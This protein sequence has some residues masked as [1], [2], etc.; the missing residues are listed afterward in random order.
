MFNLPPLHAFLK[1]R[2]PLSRLRFPENIQ[3]LMTNQEK[4]IFLPEPLLPCAFHL[5]LQL[6]NVLAQN[7]TRLKETHQHPRRYGN[8]M[9]V[10]AR[11]VHED[12]AVP[13]R[14]ISIKGQSL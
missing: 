8:E 7:E 5:P 2:R 13:V 4:I 14:R 1:F 9:L 6:D 3:M 12:G 11:I 10:P